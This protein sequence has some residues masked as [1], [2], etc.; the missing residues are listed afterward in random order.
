MLEYSL[1]QHLKLI[2]FYKLISIQEANISNSTHR[3]ISAH[4]SYRT[5]AYLSHVSWFQLLGSSAFLSDSTIQTMPST[6]FCLF[7]CLFLESVVHAFRNALKSM[8]G[9]WEV[10]TYFLFT[11]M[12]LFISLLDSLPSFFSFLLLIFFLLNV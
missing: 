8:N 6:G 7:I 10:H 3:L 12:L 11:A 2:Y 1:N 9:E 5:M 4:L